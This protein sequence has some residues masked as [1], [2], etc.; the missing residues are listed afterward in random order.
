[1]FSLGIIVYTISDGT[2][3]DSQKLRW[4]VK[5]KCRVSFQG[6]EEPWYINIR[7]LGMR[8]TCMFIVVL[9]AMAAFCFM[10]LSMDMSA[11][12]LADTVTL[13]S[14][15]AGRLIGESYS[16]D[17]EVDYSFTPGSPFRLKQISITLSEKAS[18]DNTAPLTCTVNSSLGAIFDYTLF[19]MNP[20]AL[21]ELR[22]VSGALVMIPGS[23]DGFVGSLPEMYRQGDTLD[24]DYENIEAL[25][26]AIDI[27]YEQF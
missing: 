18:A 24:F 19:K 12:V 25:T 26:V 3:D 9:A 23:D 27:L 8:Y 15:V 13:R 21:D 5:V 7:R 10:I 1:M 11:P 17:G 6:G 22:L 14:P 2:D 16:T 20:I 4:M